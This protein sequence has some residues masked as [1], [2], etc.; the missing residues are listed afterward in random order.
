MEDVTDTVF[1]RIV[2][3][4]GRPDV[5]F[6]EFTSADGLNSAGREAVIH[7]LQFTDQERPLVAQ[8]WGKSPENYYKAAQEIRALGFDG[9]DI[10]MGCPVPKIVKNGCCSALIENRSLAQ[11]LIAAALEGAGPLPVSIKTRLG[12]KR[13]CI[14]EWAEFLLGFKPA[15]LTI[16]GRTA[17]QLSK[18]AANWA[19][20][21]KA[22]K[23]RDAMNS[24]TIIIGNGDVARYSDINEK[25]LVYG[26]DGVMIGRGVFHN[27]MIFNPNGREFS[28][29][30]S[31]E[32]LRFLLTHLDLYEKTWAGV[33][34]YAV[35]K[36]FFKIYINGMRNASELRTRLVETNSFEEARGILSECIARNADQEHGDQEQT[37]EAAG[38]V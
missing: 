31:S 6:T 30:S 16:H 19:E 5:F 35:L 10:N 8:I 26:V 4:C 11:E 23:I 12:F 24:K 33:R 25:H 15:A 13:I 2:A 7:R 27:L 32:K 29:L 38:N 28:S 17:K 22:V 14:E 1:R 21:A 34:P 20:I 18:G 9:L 3:L 37:S 36:K